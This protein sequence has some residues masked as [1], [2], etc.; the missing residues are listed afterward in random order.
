MKRKK[1]GQDLLRKSLMASRVQSHDINKSQSE[2]KMAAKFL[3]AAAAGLCWSLHL[4][5]QQTAP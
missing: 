4:I 3:L 1:L 2:L 5:K